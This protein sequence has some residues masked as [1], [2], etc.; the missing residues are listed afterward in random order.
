MCGGEP[1]RVGALR[2]LPYSEVTRSAVR[3]QQKYDW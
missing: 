1:V 2:V 3:N